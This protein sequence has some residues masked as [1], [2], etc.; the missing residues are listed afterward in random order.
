MIEIEVKGSPGPQA[1]A[2]L[3]EATLYSQGTTPGS[4]VLATTHRLH[5]E[6]EEAVRTR[7][8]RDELDTVNFT[9]IDDDDDWTEV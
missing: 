8:S 7:P 6:Q 1:L 5:E 3:I 4:A 9:T 2:E